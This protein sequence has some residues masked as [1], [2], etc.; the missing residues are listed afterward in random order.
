MDPATL[1]AEAVAFVT[2]YLLDFAK[3]LGADAA[4]EGSESIWHWIKGKLASPA[5]AEAVG[6]AE[7]DPK[8]SANAQALQAALTKALKADPD[9][10]KALEALLKTSG[11]TVSS[12]TATV[13]GNANKVGQASGGSSVNIG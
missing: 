4:S 6:D 9:A 13:T 2:P 8:D 7:R 5:G 11:A 10:A 3:N 1:A 12:Q